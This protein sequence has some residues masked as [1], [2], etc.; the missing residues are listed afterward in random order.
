M[1]E[2]G[3]TIMIVLYASSGYPRHYFVFVNI[4]SIINYSHE[5]L[6]RDLCTLT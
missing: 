1:K 5:N 3:E 2:G 4:V 6:L